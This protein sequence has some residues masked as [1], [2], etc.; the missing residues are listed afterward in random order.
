VAGW[1]IPAGQRVASEPAGTPHELRARLISFFVV[2]VAVPMVA[3][4]VLLFRLIAGSAQGKADA[5]ERSCRR[6]EQPVSERGG[7]GA[8]RRRHDRPR[9]RPAPRAG[10]A[11]LGDRRAGGVGPGKTECRRG[12]LADVGDPTVVAP[13]TAILTDRAD[14]RRITVEVSELTAAQYATDLAPPGAAVVVRQGSRTLASDCSGCE[15]GNAAGEREHHAPRGRIPRRRPDFRR[16]RTLTLT[17]TVLSAVSATAT[18]L[19][20]IYAVAAV[21][22]VAFLVF[23]LALRSSRRAHS[24]Y[25]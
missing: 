20:T 15:R 19:G 10:G 5:R 7:G 21:L 14:R 6:G 24:E 12:T 22:A 4:A 9:D 23:A 17:V 1:R 13:G 25:A 8:G 11:L 3:I 18:S 16:V 2:I